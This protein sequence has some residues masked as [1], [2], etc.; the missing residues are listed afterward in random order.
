MKYRIAGAD[1]TT[2]ADVEIDVEASTEHDAREAA[3]RRGIFVSSIKQVQHSAPPAEP[4]VL[5]PTD[6]VN[7]NVGFIP[8][9]NVAPRP[10]PSMSGGKLFLIV[11]GAVACGL[12]V[13]LVGY[14]V[15]F[16]AAV[17][18]KPRSYTPNS[19][20]GAEEQAFVS[21]IRSGNVAGV[22][23]YLVKPLNWQEVSTPA[24]KEVVGGY[25]L[26]ARS[27]ESDED[28]R[29]RQFWLDLAERLIANGADVNATLLDTYDTNA[30]RF[31][32]AHNANVNA[33]SIT[34]D[35]VLHRVASDVWDDKVALL[36]A[37]GAN[38]NAVG[39]EGNT[40]LHLAAKD[41]AVKVISRLL[42]AGATINAKNNAGQ[43]P[44][45][46]ANLTMQKE[47]A[48]LL[49]SRGGTE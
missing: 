37:S 9:R 23:E 6:V 15:F 47:A 1:A 49:R 36:I 12:T 35:T 27:Y 11:T 2:G 33:R 4:P 40:P 26:E 18:T 7:D 43:T 29:D 45:A 46:I 38:V 10:S 30:L 31:L 39:Y 17:A 20:L 13:A 8:P 3:R 16:A 5:G 24:L 42:N 41:G 32:I 28:K 34:G 21:A 44:L 25:K 14:F 48:E 19:D 22:R